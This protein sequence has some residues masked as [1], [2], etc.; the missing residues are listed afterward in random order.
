MITYALQM[1][2]SS[3]AT[4][5]S[6]CSVHTRAS[7]ILN[8]LCRK[9]EEAVDELCV[10]NGPYRAVEFKDK[11]AKRPSVQYMVSMLLIASLTV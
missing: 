1:L 3:Y 9:N 8:G 10:E 11:Y 7:F 2:C 6:T 5:L 4:H